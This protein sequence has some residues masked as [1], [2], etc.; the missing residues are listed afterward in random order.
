MLAFSIR[1]IRI[2]SYDFFLIT[3]ILLALATLITL[4]YH[5]SERFSGEYDYFLWPPVAFWAFD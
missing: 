4:F 2:K 5:T 3:H 1:L